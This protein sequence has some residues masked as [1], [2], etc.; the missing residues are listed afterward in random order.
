MSVVVA[1]SFIDSII[2]MADSR[3]TIGTNKK[4]YVDN[5]LKIFPYSS[6]IIFGYVGDIRV[7]DSLFLELNKYA[8]Q[9]EKIDN[10]EI[11][12]RLPHIFK[13]IYNDVL[14]AK[15]RI[16][17]VIVSQNKN[18]INYFERNKIIKLLDIFRLGKESIKRNSIPGYLVQVLETP[19]E[20]Q[21]VGFNEFPQN[22]VCYMESPNFK[23]TFINP[24]EYLAVG[25]GDT[26]INSIEEN[27]DAVFTTSPNEDLSRY[28]SLLSIVY[29]YM[30]KNGIETVGGCYPAYVIKK[31][32]IFPLSF[33]T[34]DYSDN[35]KI[36]MQFSESGWKFIDHK[37]GKEKKLLMPYEVLSENIKSL[38]DDKI[39]EWGKYFG[40]KPK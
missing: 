28:L 15:E 38:Q 6:E 32:N 12:N 37:T 40:Y 8:K 11:L 20:S 1:C 24:F 29:S 9:L 3:V 30:E 7:I 13:K 5:A 23:P 10:V 17:L 39:E 19:K 4:I 22:L 21:F 31:N 18:Q 14:K 26:V 33:S 16:A 27:F 35:S 2:I 34:T 36:E 25:S